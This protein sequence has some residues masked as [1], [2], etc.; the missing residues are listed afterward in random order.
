MEFLRGAED[1]YLPAHGTLWEAIGA[2]LGARHP[3][4]YVTLGDEIERR[5]MLEQVGGREYIETLVEFVPTAANAGHYADIVAKKAG[6][7]RILEAASEMTG[8]AYA[9]ETVPDEDLPEKAE[10]LIQAATA[11]LGIRSSCWDHVGD[12]AGRRLKAVREHQENGGGIVGIQIRLR[13]VNEILCGIKRG[14]QTIIAARPAMGKSIMAEDFALGAAE[15]GYAVGVFA[16]EMGDEMVADRRLSR[17]ALINNRKIERANLTDDDWRALVDAKKRMDT[18]RLYTDHTSG[19]TAAEIRKR[20]RRL[21]TQFGGHL[22]MIVVDYLQLMAP[23]PSKEE[24]DN[25]HIAV[26]SNAEALRNLGK[27]LNCAM[28][29]VSQLSRAVEQRQDKRPMLSD[30]A[31]SDG[32]GRHADAVCFLYRASYYEA[33]EQSGGEE[34]ESASS[35]GGDMD[36]VEFIVA[37]NRFGP[38]GFVKLGF[39]PKFSRFVNLEENR[40]VF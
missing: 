2:M 24:R 10:R 31:E 20:A 12:G 23:G 27:E 17:E 33:K 7:R 32:I 13:A 8:W 6:R 34:P 35:Y 22:D 40:S 3:V 5:G 38:T 1:F 26:G 19:L 36:E 37:K 18:L 11:T 9:E 39:Q 29:V 14:T 16:K 4:D 28:V 25:K 30:L 21:K 15:N